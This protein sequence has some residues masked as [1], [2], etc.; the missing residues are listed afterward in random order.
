MLPFKVFAEIKHDTG[1]KVNDKREANR[2][3]RSIYKE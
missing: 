1:K 3:E 2:Q